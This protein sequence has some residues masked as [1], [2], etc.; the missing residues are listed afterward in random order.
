MF[1][2]VE[3]AVSKGLFR[4]AMLL[5]ICSTHSLHQLQLILSRTR[6][7]NCTHPLRWNSRAPP[8]VLWIL[9][10]RVL[11]CSTGQ[12]LLF[13]R[14]KPIIPSWP[15]AGLLY[16]FS[17]AW[18]IGTALPHFAVCLTKNKFLEISLLGQYGPHSR[19]VPSDCSLLLQRQRIMA[20]LYELLKCVTS[21]LLLDESVS[22]LV[23]QA[24]FH[25]KVSTSI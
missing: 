21:S 9:L 3:V 6:D 22:D 20:R 12:L 7:A 24:W 18:S 8:N 11:W 5:T 19:V 17:R 10:S 4:T 2:N 15:L 14:E 25:L 13:L 23:E 1:V 16:S